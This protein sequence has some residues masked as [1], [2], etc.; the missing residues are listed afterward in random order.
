MSQESVILFLMPG[1][2]LVHV[3]PAIVRQRIGLV[4]T[5]STPV[6][7]RGLPCLFTILGFAGVTPSAS[8]MRLPLIAWSISTPAGGCDTERRKPVLKV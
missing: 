8:D 2:N 6:G 1:S 4:A 5:E 7:V 3:P